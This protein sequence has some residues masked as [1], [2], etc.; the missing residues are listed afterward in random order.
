MTGIETVF[1]IPANPID[2]LGSVLPIQFVNLYDTGANGGNIFGLIGQLAN[3]DIGCPDGTESPT[4]ALNYLENKRDIIEKSAYQRP[5]FR[6][7]DKDLSV[8]TEVTGEMS[9]YFEELMTDSGTARYV[10]HWE[11]WVVDYLV[12]LTAVEEDLHLLIDPF[13]SNTGWETRWGGKIHTINIEKHEDGTSTVEILAI[14]NREHAKRLLIAA[15]PFFAPEVQLPRMWMLPGPCRSVLFMTFFINLARLFMPGFNTLTSIANPLSWL[16]P[17]TTGSLLQ[18]N[19]LDWPIQCA[20]V[21]PG[22]DTSTWTVLGATW[23]T[24]HDATQDILRNA[25][26]MLRAYTVLTEDKTSPYDELA[27]LVDVTLDLGINLIDDISGSTVNLNQLNTVT[28][29]ANQAVMPTRNCVV[30]RIEDNSGDH[31][32]YRNTFGW[33][34]QRYR[35][36]AG[37]FVQLG[38]DQRRYR[39]A[40]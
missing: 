8:I 26:C 39:D 2:N 19:P 6:I 14:S 30:F 22:T 31:R 29:A 34:A 18:I 23:T 13:P 5:L 21:N 38:P 12:N 40:A 36:H 4:A 27:T 9:M 1:G 37:R 3:G 15:M 28:A 25:G 7:A 20:F 16:D 17:L 24:F 10:V 32:P 33:C 35:C 11:N